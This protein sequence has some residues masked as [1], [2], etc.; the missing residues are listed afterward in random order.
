M[1]VA[2]LILAETEPEEFTPR[3]FEKLRC[4]LGGHRLCVF[5][6]EVGLDGREISC[7]CG[8]R[9]RGLDYF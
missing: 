3:R 9:S 8:K 4:I 5:T 2:S 6:G 1:K 7:R